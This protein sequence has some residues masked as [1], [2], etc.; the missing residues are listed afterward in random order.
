MI[1]P[2]GVAIIRAGF[3]GGHLVEARRH[4]WFAQHGV[5]A[6]FGLGRR[7]VADRLQQ[8][9]IVGPVDPAGVANSTASK[10]RQGPR[11]WISSV[12]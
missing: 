3:P 4:G 11:R 10:L 6:F 2:A 12:L 7:D 1:L 8:P 5:A 9:A